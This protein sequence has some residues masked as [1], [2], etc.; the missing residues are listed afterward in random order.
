LHDLAGRSGI[1]F[2]TLSAFENG[3]AVRRATA[4]KL[5]AAFEAAGVDLVAEND[6]TGAMLIYA[7]RKG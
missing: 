1:A 5:L 6:R 3:R 2:G 4:I 7:R